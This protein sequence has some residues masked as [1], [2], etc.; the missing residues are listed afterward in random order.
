MC[1][2]ISPVLVVSGFTPNFAAPE[3]FRLTPGGIILESD[4]KVDV[5]AFALTAWEL[6]HRKQ[7]WGD[8]VEKSTK[9]RVLGGERPA[10]DSSIGNSFPTLIRLMQQ[11]W[12]QSPVN[13]PSFSSMP[14]FQ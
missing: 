2:D 1:A 7:V 11:W 4:K 14:R 3:L 8:S 6:L 5:Y 13:R 9:E 10:I 12:D